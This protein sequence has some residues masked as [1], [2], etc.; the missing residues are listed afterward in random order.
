MNT[1][2]VRTIGLTVVVAGLGAGLWW[3]MPKTPLSTQTDLPLVPN[4]AIV[5]PPMLIATGGNQSAGESAPHVRIDEPALETDDPVDTEAALAV[6]AK[7][8][9]Q[10]IAPSLAAESE[11]D[12]RL[13]DLNRTGAGGGQWL[14]DLLR[15]ERQWRD[16]DG[17]KGL[18]LGLSTWQCYQG[19]CAI[20]ATFPS[21]DALDRFNTL[22]RDGLAAQPWR[23]AGFASGPIRTTRG[24]I[25]STWVFYAPP[26]GS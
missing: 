7:A 24:D 16:A 2:K 9:P 14:S 17:A 23:G 13:A 4:T 15:I 19:G 6:M 20:T 22:A 1:V 18:R 3:A 10:Q 8:K 25:E 12:G 26:T 21:V 11:R 5:S